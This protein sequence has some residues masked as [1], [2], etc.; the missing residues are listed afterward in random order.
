MGCGPSQ[1]QLDECEN[2]YYKYHGAINDALD[3]E[4]KAKGEERLIAEHQA[5]AD[6][7]DESSKESV[8]NFTESRDRMLKRIAELKWYAKEY[9]AEFEKLRQELGDAYKGETDCPTE[10]QWA[11]PDIEAAKPED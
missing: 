10:T 4:Y 7:G 8:V 3:W 5:K 2:I 9:Q 6:A 11:Y 1:D